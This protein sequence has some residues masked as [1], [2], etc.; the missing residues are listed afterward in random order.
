M[1]RSKAG[2]VVDSATIPEMSAFDFQNTVMLLENNRMNQELNDFTKRLYNTR[3]VSSKP[4]Q[5]LR[6]L[7]PDDARL[8]H[9]NRLSKETIYRMLYQHESSLG[10]IQVCNS[11]RDVISVESQIHFECSLIEQLIDG[12]S[13]LCEDLPSI[14]VIV[15][16][17]SQ[18]SAV[19]EML[20]KYDNHN[21]KADTVDR[22][23]G[24]EADIVIVSYVFFDALLIASEAEFLYNLGRINVSISRAKSCCIFMASESVFHPPVQVLVSAKA[25]VG[26]KHLMW[27]A[28]SCEDRQS[29]FALEVTQ[30]NK[31]ITC[32]F[33]EAPLVPSRPA[34]TEVHQLAQIMNTLSLSDNSQ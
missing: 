1:L 29:L 9:L 12:F 14:F 7:P 3:Y 19:Q 2:E 34:P 16:H 25:S 13:L 32:N 24:Q 6:L 15:P 22:I 4:S 20:K 8:R 23:Q 30:R 10:A 33:L 26:Y 21:V 17:R 18:R 31:V 28:N 5:N 11:K 27:F